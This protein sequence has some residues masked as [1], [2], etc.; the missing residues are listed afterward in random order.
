MKCGSLYLTKGR[1]SSSRTF[2]YSFI[3]GKLTSTPN[4]NTQGVG[5]DTPPN[6]IHPALILGEES[7]STNYP[8][9]IVTVEADDGFQQKIGSGSYSLL[10]QDLEVNEV[11][12]FPQI[13]RK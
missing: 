8:G 1:N 6:T 7:S 3:L 4:H 11:V 13:K 12:I 9:K 5:R 10:L 2:S